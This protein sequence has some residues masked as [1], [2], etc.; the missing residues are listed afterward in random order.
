MGGPC[1]WPS[2]ERMDDRHIAELTVDELEELIRKSVRHSVAEV[3]LEFALEADV[4]AQVVYQA[5]I[6]DMLRQELRG[7]GGALAFD[8]AAA[9]SDD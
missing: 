4:E 8:L 2:P 6:N 5:E 1:G 7:A 9:E 3:M